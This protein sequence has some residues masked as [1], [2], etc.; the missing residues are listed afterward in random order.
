MKNDKHNINRLS[1]LTDIKK[2]NKSKSIIE[3][4]I[5]NLNLIKKPKKLMV[6]LCGRFI[7]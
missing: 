6:V 2:L 5:K 1:R 3:M 4:V 7:N